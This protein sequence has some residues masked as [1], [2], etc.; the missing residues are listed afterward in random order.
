MNKYPDM[1]Q[2]LEEIIK[3]KGET[4]HRL[5]NQQFKDKKCSPRTYNIKKI[6]IESWVIKE[7]EEVKL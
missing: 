4:D 6:E 1:L 3:R 7:K 2:M 5:L